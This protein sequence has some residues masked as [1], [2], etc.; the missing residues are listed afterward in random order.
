MKWL[1]S[2]N[3]QI[4]SA[5]VGIF[6]FI[7]AFLGTPGCASG[8][9]ATPEDQMAQVQVYIDQ[10]RLLQEEVSVLQDAVVNAQVLLLE[11]REQISGLEEG[12]DQYNRWFRVIQQ[13][14]EKVA[15]AET[16]MGTFEEALAK[17]EE[18]LVAIRDRAAAGEV[19]SV[20]AEALG[21]TIKQGAPLLPPPFNVI[22]GL[23]GTGLVT[24]S[25]RKAIRSRKVNE[26][27]VASV[28]ELLDDD[29]VTDTDRAKAILEDVQFKVDPK[30]PHEVKKIKIDG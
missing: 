2:V 3:K 17:N 27:I 20:E 18:S 8:P 10:N 24:Y 14:E 30:T 7:G 28:N 21:T 5:V 26:A 19:G 9:E 25:S 1:S 6:M 15:E 22:A 16:L 23:I 29:V 13:T 12:T 4:M 11:A